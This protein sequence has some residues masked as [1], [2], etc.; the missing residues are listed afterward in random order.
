MEQ[1]RIAREAYGVILFFF[2]KI[3]GVCGQLVGWFCGCMSAEGGIDGRRGRT[4]SRE[5]LKSL[6]CKNFLT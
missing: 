5:I 1:V 4:D 2:W 6:H 3:G